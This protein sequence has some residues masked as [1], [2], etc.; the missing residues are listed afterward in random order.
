VTTLSV[1]D[2]VLYDIN[3]V[4]TADSVRVHCRCKNTLHLVLRASSRLFSDRIK[5]NHACPTQAMQST[6][7]AAPV[8]NYVIQKRTY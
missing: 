6:E 5:Y 2:Q 7:L 8:S 3:L 4:A 1:R